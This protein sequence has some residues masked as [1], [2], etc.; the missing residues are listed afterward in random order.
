[1][2]ASTVLTSQL[3]ALAGITGDLAT[4][5]LDK[6]AAAVADDL[7]TVLRLKGISEA[8]DAGSVSSYTIGGRSVSTSMDLI[9]KALRL[10]DALASSGGRVGVS[11]GM[12]FSA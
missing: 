7:R 8:I 4:A 1:M 2:A 12:E 9:E 11:V 5:L 3:L 6:T 10:V